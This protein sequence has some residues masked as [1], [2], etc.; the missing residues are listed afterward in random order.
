MVDSFRP[1]FWPFMTNHIQTLNQ[2]FSFL[3]FFFLSHN[4]QKAFQSLRDPSSE[5][6]F[7]LFVC[8][9]FTLILN[10][11]LLILQL[12]SINSHLICR[13]QF[14]YFKKQNNDQKLFHCP[15]KLF[16]RCNHSTPWS[17]LIHLVTETRKKNNN[18]S[19]IDH[20]LFFIIILQRFDL[21][22]QQK[23]LQKFTK[24]R[25]Q[26]SPLPHFDWFIPRWKKKEGEEEEHPK[27]RKNRL[28]FFLQNSS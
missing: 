27:C 21:I 7:Y 18:D 28:S 22:G 16:Q 6:Y 17:C 20:K 12:N 25:L 19:N 5:L 14:S 2:P 10:H 9:F 23:A 15:W 3:F 1:I 8:F 24:V 11:N 13:L 4:H 26:N